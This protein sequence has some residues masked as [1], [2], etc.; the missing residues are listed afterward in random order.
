[1]KIQC[2]R[3]L[4]FVLTI[5]PAFGTS[6]AYGE[7]HECDG[8]WTNLPCTGTIKNSVEESKRVIR[9]RPETTAQEPS[10]ASPEASSEAATD[11]GTSEIITAPLAPRSELARRLRR[12]SDEHKRNGGV[13]FSSAE[14]ESFRRYCEEKTRTIDECHTS[15]TEQSQH[16]IEINKKEE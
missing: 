10:M 9:V 5:V 16:L 11:I 12:E 14:L 3:K 8:K 13:G 4:L 15:Y 7:L 6:I 2:V 1:M